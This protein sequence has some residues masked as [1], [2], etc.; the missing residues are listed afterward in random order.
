VAVVWIE[1]ANLASIWK[2]LR[3]DAAGPIPFRGSQQ[4]DPLCLI[5]MGENAREIDD[6]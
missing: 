3:I 1:D 2:T 4:M 6:A 5:K